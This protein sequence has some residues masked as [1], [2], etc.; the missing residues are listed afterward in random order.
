MRLNGATWGFGGLVRYTRTSGKWECDPTLFMLWHI[1]SE[2]FDYGRPETFDLT[3]RM[4]VVLL[5][6]TALMFK[7]LQSIAIN[8]RVNWFPSTVTSVDGIPNLATLCLIE[9]LTSLVIVVFAVG[10]AIE[11]ASSNLVWKGRFYFLFWSSF[12]N[13]VCWWS[14]N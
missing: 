6:A 4:Q 3:I 5:L 9:T 13:Q 10:I 12:I 8:L 14:W 11:A 1:V 7:S 2:S